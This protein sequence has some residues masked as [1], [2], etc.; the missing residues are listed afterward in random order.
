VLGLPSPPYSVNRTRSILS[1]F[2]GSSGFFDYVTT[3]LTVFVRE[4]R[5]KIDRDEK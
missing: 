2:S 3:A 1:G 5:N 4:M